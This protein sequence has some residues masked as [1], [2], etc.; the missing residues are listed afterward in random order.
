MRFR[1]NRTVVRGLVLSGATA[2]LL[3]CLAAPVY[4]FV[5]RL[6]DRGYKA[7]LLAATILWFLCAGALTAA[8]SKDAR[9]QS[10]QK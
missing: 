6:E 1:A 5:G 7:V 4:Y 10:E 2:G 8:G 3:V 9:P